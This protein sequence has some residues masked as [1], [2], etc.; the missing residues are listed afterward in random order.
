MKKIDNLKEMQV[1]NDLHFLSSTIKKQLEKRETKN[2]K[3]LSSSIIRIIF[4]FQEYSNNIKLYKKAISEYR[5]A[6]NKAILRARN[7][8]EKLKKI[9]KS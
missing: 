2:L 9:N 3:K 7:L 8:E 5:L 6:K 4:Y 1:W